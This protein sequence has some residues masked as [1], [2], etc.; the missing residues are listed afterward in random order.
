TLTPT[1]W[2][3]PVIKRIGLAAPLDLNLAAHPEFTGA[4]MV[5][6][7]DANNKVAWIDW[8]D[9]D[10]KPHSTPAIIA[11]SA[12]VG[13]GRIIYMSY[14]PLELGQEDLFRNV[15]MWAVGET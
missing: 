3:H 9:A 14:D 6:E 1:N 5:Q 13:G 10:H 15:I 8:Y 11:Y 12:G 2:D 4:V 7:V